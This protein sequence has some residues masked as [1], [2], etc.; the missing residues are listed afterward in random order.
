MVRALQ[1]DFR[2]VAAGA[3]GMKN[4]SLVL[5]VLVLIVFV[6][7]VIAAFFDSAYISYNDDVKVKA[8]V[9]CVFIFG[10]LVYGFFNQKV[11]K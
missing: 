2:I 1:P 8:L 6:Y 5:K 3:G 4:K 11:K 9:S 10:L 7:F